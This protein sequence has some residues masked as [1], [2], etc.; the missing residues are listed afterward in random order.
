MNQKPR[1]N[2]REVRQAASGEVSIS[3]TDPAP[4]KIRGELVDVSVSGFRARHSFQSLRS[5]QVVEY[6]HPFGSGT[7][8]VIWNRIAGTDIETG[9]VLL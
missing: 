4:V 7:A 8:Q 9:F 3:F 5:G 6:S 2:R 1:E